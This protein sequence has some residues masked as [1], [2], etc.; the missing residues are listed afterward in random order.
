MFIT[1]PEVIK[2]VTREDVSFEELGGA[3]VHGSKSGVCHL[4]G[5][6]D[7]DVLE[8]I[9]TLL[10]YLPN[11]AKETT[12][13]QKSTDPKTRKNPRLLEI[14]HPDQRKPY[15]MLEVI[16]EIVDGAEF[17]EIQPAFAKNMICGFARL[18]GRSV[19]IVANNPRFMAGVLNIDAS[20]KAARFIRTC[21]CYNVP[22]VTLV[23]VTGFL[24][25]V[26]Q[27]HQGIIRHGAKMLYA[28]AEASV[29]KIT[30]ITRKSYGGAYLAMNSRDMGADVVLAYPNA[31]VAVMGAEGAAN[32]IYRREILKSDNQAATR[33]EKIAEYK[34][35]FDNPYVAASRGY[36][37]DVI[38]PEDTRT[39]LILHLE[40][41]EGKSEP[42]PFK[43]HDNIPL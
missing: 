2:S 26:A 37:D 34:T 3:D 42:R 23:D 27:E 30:L 43:K 28:Y 18:G 9:K 5:E 24:P 10:S 15:P 8:K 20:D 31:A 1:G 33:A 32:I 40:M 7:R 36:I 21:D 4:E 16:H 17:M 29:P 6:D 13:L 14:I 41:L 25:G 19:G 35:A 38:H 22:I 11:N 12:P 39:H